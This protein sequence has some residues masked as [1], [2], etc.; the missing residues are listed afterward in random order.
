M[1]KLGR[2][3]E[4]WND[5]VAM[6]ALLN[7]ER[8]VSDCS[9]KFRVGRNRWNGFQILL[10]VYTG[11]KPGEN[12]RTTD[13]AGGDVLSWEAGGRGANGTITYAFTLWTGNRWNGFQ[14]WLAVYTGLKPGENER[15]TNKT[16]AYLKKPELN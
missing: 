7:C 13:K 10:A 4:E 16:G 11:L 9:S 1:K 8:W 5:Y 15:T 14:I 3:G 6:G 2:R 12:E